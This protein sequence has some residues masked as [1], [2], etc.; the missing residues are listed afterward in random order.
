MTDNAVN[1]GDCVLGLAATADTLNP[2]LSTSSA[3]QRRFHESD[4]DYPV[5]VQISDM[6][7]VINCKDDIQWIVQAR[8]NAMGKGWRGS[9]FCRTREALIRCASPLPPEALAIL[10]ALPEQHQ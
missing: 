6:V 10:R 8:R 5:I 2:A 9:S 4:D 3:R 1:A 7:R